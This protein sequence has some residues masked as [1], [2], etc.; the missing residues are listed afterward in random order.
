MAKRAAPAASSHP[1][2]PASPQGTLFS[3]A[4]R[5][6][7]LCLVYFA[8][9]KLGLSLAFLHKSATPVWP[10]TGIALASL[11]VYG[12]GVW[13]AILLGAFLV[14]ITT[15]GSVATCLGI[16]AGNTLE[17][18]VGAFLIN[19][20]A[21]G[22]HAFDRIQ[23]VFKFAA[24]APVAS[25]TVSATIGVLSLRLGGLATGPNLESVWLT[26]WLGD[27]V[28]ALVVGPF[29]VLWLSDPKGCLR[30][31]RTLEAGAVF[32]VVV[33]SGL[34]VFGGLFPTETKTYPLEFLCLLPLLWAAF[35]LPQSGAAVA[36]LALSGLAIWGTLR[37]FGP[38]VRGSPNE[39]L[40]L[41][42]AFLGVATL[43]TLALASVVSERETFERQLVYFVDH[44]LLTGMLSRRRFE[45]EIGRELAITS[46]YGTHGALIYLDLDDFKVV[47]DRLGHRAGDTLLIHLASL[48]KDRLR[49]SD[50][51][52]RMGGDE[53]AILAPHTDESQARAL[54][55]QLVAAIA[56]D[57]AAAS[58]RHQKITASLGVALYPEHGLTVDEL[59]SR[60]DTAMY[61]A[62]RE[63][64]NGFRMHALAPGSAEVL[65]ALPTSRAR[66]RR[67]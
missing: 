42:Q 7:L 26:W 63:G 4:S 30:D 15:E 32:L 45:A 10:P 2:P 59:L 64:G 62:K 34:V 25:T 11:L 67:G 1:D 28:G 52:A 37:G 29:L 17:G 41:Q 27:A 47:N 33:L 22:R 38:F 8:A 40:L 14:N 55:A 61:E 58:D 24:L 54:A 65:D 6:T 12:Y 13:P 51:L 46:R 56:E 35:R 9:G 49:D 16:A 19:R 57:G 43:T 39:S 3:V 53:V 60:A 50:L 36:S 44:D 48:L 5:L 31:A 18:L 66:R 21:H 23:D 20:F